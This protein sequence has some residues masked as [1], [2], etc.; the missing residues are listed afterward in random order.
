MFW[1]HWFSNRKF[2]IKTFHIFLSNIMKI[3]RRYILDQLLKAKK[4]I[5]IIIVMKIGIH[6]WYADFKAI[7]H[8]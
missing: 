3:V 2:R 1:Q 7:G 4:V 8:P 6:F 5:K